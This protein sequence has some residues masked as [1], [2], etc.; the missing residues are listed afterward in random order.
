M[1]E[2]HPICLVETI[3]GVSDDTGKILGIY[4]TEGENEGIYVTSEDKFEQ[5]ARKY[6]PLI[7]TGEL[8]E[9]FACLK[10]CVPQKQ[11]C[12]EKNLIA[13][14]NGIFDFDTKQL[15]S[16]T[17]DLVFLSKSR[18]DYKVNVQ[19][20]V[21]H[22][23]DDGTDWDVE[24]WMADLSDDPS[25]VHLLWQILGAIIRP[26]VA[27]D[28]TAWFYYESGNNGKG[29]LCELMREL[30]GKKSY[31]AIPLAD[32]SKDF[33]LTQLLNASAV[34]VDE[35]DVG[36]YIDRAANFKAVVT[37]D[38]VTINRKFKDPEDLWYSA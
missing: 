34:I 11:K 33:Y 38:A 27:W 19:N 6:N 7:S 32:F 23:N 5:L 22:N 25:V 31:A 36:T 15:R 24:S 35:N 28:R 30:C 37:G 26:N 13:V 14:N 17:P 29:T 20:P 2:L 4:Q 12:K 16:F 21:I 10:D 8:K 1:S 3:D 18:V 9:M